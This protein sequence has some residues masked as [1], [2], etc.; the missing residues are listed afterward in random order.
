MR[1][2]PPSPSVNDVL[3]FVLEIIEVIGCL[4]QKTVCLECIGHGE[5]TLD[6]EFG[7]LLQ[8]NTVRAEGVE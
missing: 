7:L 2:F 5:I 4:Y 6:V 3:K 8:T 1:V